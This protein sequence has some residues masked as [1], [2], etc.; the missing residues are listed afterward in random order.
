MVRVELYGRDNCGLC[1]AAAEKLDLLKVP[2]EKKPI[3][4]MMQ[5]HEGWQVDDSVSV[6]AAYHTYGQT[7]PILRVGNEFL[8]YPDAMRRLKRDQEAPNRS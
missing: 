4:P 3:D 8:S 1:R 6:L 5:L 2:Y 7:L